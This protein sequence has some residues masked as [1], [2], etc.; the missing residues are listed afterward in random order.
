MGQE[1]SYYKLVEAGDIV[2]QHDESLARSISESQTI[3]A[4]ISATYVVQRPHK[5][6]IPIS[7]G[8]LLRT[9]QTK[10]KETLMASHQI[11]G[12]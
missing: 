9:H 10:L 3:E 8:Y 5:G 12:A 6:I 1:L 2:L 7:Y 4:V 11:R